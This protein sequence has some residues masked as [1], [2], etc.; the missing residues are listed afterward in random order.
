[1]VPQLAVHI[2]SVLGLELGLVGPMEPVVFLLSLCPSEK[3]VICLS[4]ARACSL[5][6]QRKVIHWLKAMSDE[7]DKML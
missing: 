7:H 3:A 6:R 2:A 5:Y 4:L 1:M